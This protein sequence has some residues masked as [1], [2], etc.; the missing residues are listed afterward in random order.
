MK[1]TDRIYIAG[2]HGMVGSAI[3]RHLQL[4]G[5]D[6]IV[7]ASRNEL[8]LRDAKSAG[9]F[10]REERPD[11]VFL[12]AARVGGIQAN[13]DNPVDFLHDNLMIQNNVIRQC[14]LNKVKK[15]LF[16]ASSCVYP[17][18]CAQPMK[19]EYLLTGPLEPTN[20]GYSLAKIAGLKLLE[21][22]HKQYGLASVNP[23][24]CNIYGPNDNFDVKKAHVLS[25]LV[26]RFVDAVEEDT[27]EVTLWGSG[28]ARREFMHV[29]DLAEAC[30][31]LMNNHD[32]HEP[33]NV[34]WGVDVSINE[35]AH[36]MAEQIGYKGEIKWDT[37]KP[38][39]MP[40]KCLD[41]SRM[42]TLGFE[43]RISLKEGISRMIQ[44]YRHLK[45]GSS[46]N[47]ERE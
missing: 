8:D 13:I 43:P 15:V 25:S 7:T 40:R 36:M 27:S 9:E 44:Y 10:F 19:E 46:S 35:L 33:I 16:L 32:S 18:E 12:A 5:Y 31:F 22:Y 45:A 2:H 21:Y 38:D 17:R 47:N 42:E 26:R 1:K 41:T 11:Y 23:V 34:G 28:I 24:P 30:L 14:H 4:K 3:Q 39:G 29:D 6:N 20:E 37:S